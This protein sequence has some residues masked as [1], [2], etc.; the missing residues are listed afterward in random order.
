VTDAGST[1]TGQTKTRALGKTGLQ[2]SALGVGTNKWSQGSNDEAV[3]ETF[4]T[5]QDAGISFFDTAE[6]YGFGKSERL[7]GD[8]LRRDGRP[9]TIA[10]KFAPFIARSGSR[11]LLKALDASLARLGVSAIDLYYIHFPYPFAD[12]NELADAMIE[13]VKAGKVRHVGVSNFSAAQMRRVADRL[14]RSNIPLAANEVHYSLLARKAESNGVLDACRELGA[15]LIAY[16]PLARG[17]LTRPPAQGKTGRLETLQTTLTDIAQAHR[18]SPSQVALN[19]LL[20]RDPCI[21]PIPGASTVKNAKQNI[22]ALDWNLT[23]DEF[24]AID[25][26]SASWR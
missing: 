13:A 6:V 19:W 22:A 24:A 18:A 26:A 8:C 16:F 12:F 20:A 9:A 1:K 2:V 5:F 3:F 25:A 21:I 11:H 15:S 23:G 10:T 14:S 7:I 17:R 4:Q